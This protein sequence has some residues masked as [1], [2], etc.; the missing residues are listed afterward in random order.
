MM[1][2]S[3]FVLRLGRSV[4]PRWPH[5]ATL[6]KSEYNRAMRAA[7]YYD[8]LK[9]RRPAAQREPRIAAGDIPRTVFE[10]LYRE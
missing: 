9:S 10:A 2:A 1:G 5:A 7:R 8:N 6:I 4:A 3:F